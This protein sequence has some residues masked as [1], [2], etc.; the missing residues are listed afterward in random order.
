MP[1]VKFIIDTVGVA[2]TAAAA[3]AAA[4]GTWFAR[5]STKASLEAVKEARQAR[6]DEIL[7]RLIL[8]KNF[9]DLSFHWP[10]PHGLNGGAVFLARRHWQDTD[11][12]KPTFSLSNFGQS[13]AL[14]L[15]I[16]FELEDQNGTFD[17]DEG[18]HA[19]G[20]SIG[21]GPTAGTVEAPILSLTRDGRGT[22]TPL[23]RRW[24]SEVPNCAPGQTRSIEL[25]EHIMA[26]LFARGL[27]YSSRMLTGNSI[28]E[29]VLT[30]QIFFYTVEGEP[31]A[32]QFRFRILPFCYGPSLPI[33]VFGHVSELP[34]YPPPEGPKVE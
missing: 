10:H 34:M 14:E 33:E 17:L 27:Q 28:K 30:V 18:F 29:L 26:R 5:Q 22:G 31:V 19:V 16:V 11:P 8:E 32:T 23:Y 20:I 24:T 1:D 4:V 7:P 12:S 15:S 2:S 6:R 9:L 3:V 25:P 21:D 13:P